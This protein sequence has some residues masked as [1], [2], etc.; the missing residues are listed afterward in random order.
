MVGLVDLGSIVGVGDFVDLDGIVGVWGIG[1][2]DMEALETWSGASTQV[3]SEGLA[4]SGLH[5]LSCSQVGWLKT[6]GTGSAG[7]GGHTIALSR[8]TAGAHAMGSGD[9]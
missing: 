5:A 8:G 4:Y 3:C 7:A 1:S 2:I 6:G 9:T